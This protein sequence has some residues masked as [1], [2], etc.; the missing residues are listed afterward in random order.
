MLSSQD[1]RFS[2]DRVPLGPITRTV[3]HLEI[4]LLIRAARGHRDDVVNVDACQ[5]RRKPFHAPRAHPGLL[6]GQ[7]GKNPDPASA[8][9]QLLVRRAAATPERGELGTT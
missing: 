9:R 7:A 3:Q 5:V 6:P 2:R 4:P 1:D 8:R